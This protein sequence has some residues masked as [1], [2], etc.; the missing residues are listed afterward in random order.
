MFVLASDRSSRISAINAV[1]V[2]AERVS[3]TVRIAAVAIAS[4]RR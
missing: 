2:P 3:L 4:H 1:V